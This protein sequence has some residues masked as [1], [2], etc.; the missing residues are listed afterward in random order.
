RDYSISHPTS[1]LPTYFSFQCHGPHR[2]LH[3]FPTR[4]SSDL[5]PAYLDALAPRIG[6]PALV[7]GLDSGCGNY[8]QLWA[9]ASLRGLLNGVLRSEEHTSELQSRFDLVC[10]LLLEKKKDQYNKIE[11]YCDT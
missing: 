3:S 8:E 6:T 4:R 1:S 2:A 10:R 7:I 9:T 5:L 11:E